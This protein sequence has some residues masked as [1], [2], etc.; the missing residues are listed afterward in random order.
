[1]ATAEIT[2]FCIENGELVHAYGHERRIYFF[3]EG[4]ELNYSDID[5]N[6]TYNPPVVRATRIE[7]RRTKARV[8]EPIQPA[9]MDISMEHMAKFIKEHQTQFHWNISTQAQEMLPKE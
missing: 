5:N 3:P 4:A 6:F 2:S 7:N 8:S 1:M 9:Q